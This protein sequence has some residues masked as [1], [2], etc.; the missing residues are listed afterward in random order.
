MS[1]KNIFKVVFI[2]LLVNHFNAQEKA[3]KLWKN[4]PNEIKNKSY[5]QEIRLNDKGQATGIKKVT[6]PT[7][8]VFLVDNTNNNN[9]GVIIFPG[10]GYSVLSHIKEGYK[11]A[12]WFNSIGISAFVLHY[13][14]PSDLIM[15]DKSIGPLQD[16]QEA[17]RKVRRN[18]KKWNLDPN[19]I[20]VIGFSAGGHLASTISTHYKDSVYKNDAISAKPDFS[21]LIY[22]VISMEKGI[23]HQGS[24][25]KLLGNNP[26][27]ALI[28]KYSNEK[29]ITKETPP[30]FL[31]HATNDKSVLVENSIQ[32]YLKLKENNVSAE[33]HLY[34]DGGHGFGLGKKGT[35]TNWPNEV[36]NWLREKSLLPKKEIY[37]FSYF[38]G[39]GEDGLRLAYSKNGYDFI[40]LN[41]DKSFLEPKVGK[42]KLMRDPCIIKGDDGLFHMVWTVSWTDKGIGYASSKDLINWSKQKFIPVME[43]ENATRNTWAPEITYQA[44]KK[45]YMI[46][47]SSTVFGKF[48]ETQIT[49]DQGYNHRIYYTKTKDFETFTETKLLYDPGFNAIDASIQKD[50]NRFIMFLKDETKKP[51]QK[52]LKVS[53]AKKITGPYTKASKAITGNYWSEGP[54]AIKIKGSWI[55]YFDKYRDHKYGA[56][57]S[58]DLKN[59][60]DISDQISFPKGARHG[61]IFTISEK[62]FLNLLKQ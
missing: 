32:Y 4:V 54:T 61:S 31:V 22:P 23:T 24:K 55:V 28:E 11:I 42:D 52:N 6:D 41:N 60:E 37:M 38:K 21:L 58:L 15:Q 51:I 44:S 5:S 12:K 2:F 25:N 27:K 49:E 30:T 33:M 46:Y 34:Q 17:I 59:W 16:A 1:K 19:K 48:P 3:I 10:G 57:K 14:L 53:F 36:E 9:T 8:Q 45:E 56:V 40:A 20:G 13:R 7:L 50:G 43:K 39:N 29:H 26:S 35:H 62:E 47:W 18:A